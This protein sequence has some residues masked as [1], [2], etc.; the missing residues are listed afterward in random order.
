[1]RRLLPGIVLFIVVGCGI[2]PKQYLIS[3]ERPTTSKS[4]HT[5]IGIDKII[6]PGYMEE[7]KIAIKKS[8]EEIEYR[9]GIWAV[10]VSK[11]LTQAL[12]RSLQQRQSNPNIH[13][14]P[15]DIERERGKRVKVTISEFIYK[16]GAVTLEATYFIKRIGSNHKKS[17]MFTTRVNSDSS[18][19]AIVEA[20]SRAFS[21][22]VG[23]LGS[24]L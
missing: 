4:N 22:L 12:I 3:V 24:R 9:N 8:G 16:D 18:T 5:Q 21:R 20:M 23:E 11:A 6:V 15:W 19:A 1:M 7:S 17:Y 13:L 14:Y 2:T 10:P